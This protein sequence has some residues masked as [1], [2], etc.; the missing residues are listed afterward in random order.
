[1]VMFHSH[2]SSPEGNA[3][4]IFKSIGI[5]QIW[6]LPSLCVYHLLSHP[7]VAQRVFIRIQVLA[8]VRGGTFKTSPNAGRSLRGSPFLPGRKTGGKP[9]GNW[10]TIDISSGGVSEQRSYGCSYI[11]RSEI[12][13][14]TKIEFPNHIQLQVLGDLEHFGLWCLLHVPRLFLSFVSIQGLSIDI[15]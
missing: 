7:V 9:W 11:L 6:L 14:A 1:M 15:F 4:D 13:G 12:F 5:Y 2:I 3:I 10:A 8:P